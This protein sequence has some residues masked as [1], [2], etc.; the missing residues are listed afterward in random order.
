KDSKDYGEYL[1]HD[2]PDERKAYLWNL[3]GICSY[4]VSEQFQESNGAK[5]RES[6]DCFNNAIKLVNEEPIYWR[7]YALMLYWNSKKS[8]KVLRKAKNAIDESI[9]RFEKIY[10]IH[11]DTDLYDILDK[12]KL[13][14]IRSTDTEKIPK[15]IKIFSKFDK[16]ET[17][18]LADQLEMD[19]EECLEWIISLPDNLG[20]IISNNKIRIDHKKFLENKYLLEDRNTMITKSDVFLVLE[21]NPISY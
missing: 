12:I 6:L 20:F 10:S 19:H 2:K 14:L 21:A 13:E 15:I 4:L 17:T 7:N 1:Q 3:I 9:V 18:I 16:I 11:H 8:K 5:I